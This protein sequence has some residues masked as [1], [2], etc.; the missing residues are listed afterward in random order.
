M[1]PGE[2]LVWACPRS[3]TLEFHSLA[4]RVAGAREMDEDEME[5]IAGGAWAWAL[6]L[7]L[8]ATGVYANSSTPTIT[9]N[10]LP[11]DGMTGTLR[12]GM[13]QTAMERVFRLGRER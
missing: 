12:A 7:Q 5:R 3:H 6:G 9:G 8:P 10:T 13:G 2:A 4:V 1:M 11:A